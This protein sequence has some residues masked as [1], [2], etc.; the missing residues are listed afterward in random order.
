[1]QKQNEESWHALYMVIRPETLHYVK[2]CKSHEEYSFN[3]LHMII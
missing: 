2:T 1:M 3:M